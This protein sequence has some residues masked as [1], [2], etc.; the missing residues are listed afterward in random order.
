MAKQG[1]DPTPQ[2]ARHGPGPSDTIRVTQRQGE[3]FSCICRQVK[4][5]WGPKVIGEHDASLVDERTGND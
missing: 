4:D 5:H 3:E 1:V 2:G